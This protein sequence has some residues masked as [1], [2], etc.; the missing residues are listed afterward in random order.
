L[1]TTTDNFQ[2][3]NAFGKKC[4]TI[5]ASFVLFRRRTSYLFSFD[6]SWEFGAVVNINIRII[7]LLNFLLILM[8]EMMIPRDLGKL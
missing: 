2:Y 4:R 8:L 1:Q 3:A 6:I 5:S 7:Q